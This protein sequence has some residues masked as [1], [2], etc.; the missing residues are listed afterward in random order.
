VLAALSIASAAC[1][2]VRMSDLGAA[3]E[4]RLEVF[5]DSIGKLLGRK[6]RRASFAAYVIG[7]LSEAERKSVEP[8]AGRLCEE[9]EQMDAAH[10]RLLHFVTDST[11]SDVDVR[12]LASR[13][14]LDAMAKRSPIATWIID[15][16]GFLKQGSHSVGVQ[17][18]Y[19]GSAGKIANCQIGVSLTVATAE[20][21]VPIDFELY[22]PQEW[23]SSKKLR[24]EARIP[25]SVGFKTKPELALDMIVRA[26]ESGVPLGVLLADAAYGDNV[27]FRRQVHA[28]GFDYALGVNALTKV[29]QL[30]RAGRT[31]GRKRSV[32][33]VALELPSK[34]LTWR[35]GTKGSMRGRFA[36]SRVVPGFIDPD[37]EMK[38]REDVWL[39]AEFRKNETKYYFCTLPTST[40]HSELVRVIK[41]RYRT[42]QVYLELK[43]ELGLDHYEGRR[44]PGWHHHVTVALCC[45]AFLVAERARG[46][47]PS[48]NRNRRK[49]L[50][51]S[52]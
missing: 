7:L 17:R 25:D 31:R 41:E 21:H 47:P 38:H 15:D 3:A 35:E 28:L 49:S 39:V 10:Q 20:L 24:K 1:S 30:D 26:K 16:T 34:R 9:P 36:F 23:A 19:T 45:Y 11:W 33:D 18:Q 37:I 46:F 27:E 2:M 6:E 50:S 52:P 29:E 43:G 13:Y 48:A 22:L 42:E 8:L 44:F 32:R 4:V 12:S 5:L 51:R 14:A 40:T